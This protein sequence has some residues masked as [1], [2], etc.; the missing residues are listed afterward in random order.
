ME[1]DGHPSFTLE[2]P[3]GT[4]PCSFVLEQVLEQ[5]RFGQG[6]VQPWERFSRLT[7]QGPRAPHEA[8]LWLHLL[9]QEFVSQLLSDPFRS[10][11]REPVLP[12]P[13]QHDLAPLGRDKII[14][15]A[16]QGSWGKPRV[17]L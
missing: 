8:H 6:F 11:V 14:E 4:H 9:D 3:N 13:K 2:V 12:V 5:G 1:A 10:D 16:T 15:C 7:H 17:S